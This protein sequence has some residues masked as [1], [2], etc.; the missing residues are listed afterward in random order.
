MN[1]PT[2]A[3]FTAEHELLRAT[4][5]RFVTERVKPHAD[6]WEEARWFPQELF[7]RMGELG[8]L[9]LRYDPATVAILERS[10]AT[11]DTA[12][13]EAD[14]VVK[15]DRLHFHRF[16]STPLECAGALVGFQSGEHG[17]EV[18]LQVS[19]AGQ[20]GVIP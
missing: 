13:A 2:S 20:A 15:I 7:P 11:I 19:L 8:F 9:G 16:S 1:S 12:L 18:E 3:F 6:A 14:H 17:F 4:V 5:R 10:L